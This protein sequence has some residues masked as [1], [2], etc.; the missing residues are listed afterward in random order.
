MSTPLKLGTVIRA[1]QVEGAKTQLF[2]DA[3]S[4]TW[5]LET[6]IKRSD[7]TLDNVRGIIFLGNEDAP[8]AIWVAKKIP[9][10]TRKRVQVSDPVELVYIGE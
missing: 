1:D 2:D 7:L 3:T 8:D 4:I 6:H 5:A 10:A 9:G